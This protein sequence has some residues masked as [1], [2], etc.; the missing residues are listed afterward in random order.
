MK[1][2]KVCGVEAH[3]EIIDAHDGYCD[4]CI[5][6]TMDPDW[7]KAHYPYVYGEEEEEDDDDDG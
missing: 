6:E 4:D 2:C 3:A 5:L 1:T 7:V